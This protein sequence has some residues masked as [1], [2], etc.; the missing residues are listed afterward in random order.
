MSRVDRR[1][2]ESQVAIKNAV[3]DLLSEKSFDYITIQDIADRADVNRG[4]ICYS[5]IF[6]FS[7]RWSMEWW[8]MNGKPL[9]ARVMGEQTGALLDRNLE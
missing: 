7:S 5:S 6:W 8:F 9:P 2:A 4:T 3:I 1:I